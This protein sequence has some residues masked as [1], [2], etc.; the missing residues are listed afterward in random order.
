MKKVFK[1]KTLCKIKKAQANALI[2]TLKKKKINYRE[3]QIKKEDEAQ[4]IIFLF[5]SRDCN[6]RQTVKY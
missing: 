6:N 5:Y 1:N 3:F 2:K 4:R